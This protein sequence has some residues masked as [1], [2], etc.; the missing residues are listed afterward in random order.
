MLNFSPQFQNP[1]S[2]IITDKTEWVEISGMYNATGGEKYIVIG[3]FYDDS[4]S[5]LIPVP[6]TLVG[7][8]AAYYYIDDVSIKAIDTIHYPASAG[9]DTSICLGDSI[10]IGLYDF[11]D[12]NY[13]WT[14]TT[15]INCDSIG[16]PWVK[17]DTTTTYYLYQVDNY[18][19]QKYDTVTV[20]VD[21]Y[22]ANAGP[23]TVICKGDSIQI[24]THNY[25]HH[26]YKWRSEVGGNIIYGVIADSTSGTTIVY[27]DTSTL[28]VLKSV[29]STG[30]PSW[31]S[32]FITVVDCD[33]LSVSEYGLENIRL[34]PNPANGIVYVEYLASSYKSERSGDPAYAGLQAASRLEILDLY[35]K[36]LVSKE[37]NGVDKRLK[38]DVSGLPDGIYFLRIISEKE[39]VQRKVVVLKK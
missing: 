14:A 3:N 9:N 12:Y 29:D 39:R 34:Y 30:N 15:Y 13:Q 27:P 19:V 4:S 11:S 38:I 28:F 21:C 6:G 17:P 8:H 1:D 25:S 26:A 23:D 31:D 35:G 33:T 32:V 22:P 5:N 36:V 2:N 10:R 37:I 20:H 24:G 18:G 16:N 7:I